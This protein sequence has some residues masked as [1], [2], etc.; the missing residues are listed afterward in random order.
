MI[1]SSKF[2]WKKDCG[3]AS[4]KELG[5][6]GRSPRSFKVQSDRTG[7]VV[8]FHLEE[9]IRYTDGENNLQGVDS[10]YESKDGWKVQVTWYAY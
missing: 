5:W 6:N 8:E 3:F 10:N 2:L 7:D 1:S 4:D 9:Q